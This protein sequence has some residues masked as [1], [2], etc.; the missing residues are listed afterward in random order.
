MT[1]WLIQIGGYAALVLLFSGISVLTW[2]TPAERAMRALPWYVSAA[3]W[4]VVLPVAALLLINAGL[5]Y[6]F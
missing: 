2:N 6:L 1:H 5:A 4:W 3:M